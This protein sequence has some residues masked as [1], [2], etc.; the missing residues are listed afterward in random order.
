MNGVGEERRLSAE[1]RYALVLL[2]KSIMDQIDEVAYLKSNGYS[3]KTSQLLLEEMCKVVQEMEPSLQSAYY[4]L[5]PK[6][7]G[8]RVTRKKFS[9]EYAEGSLKSKQKLLQS[10]RVDLLKSA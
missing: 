9:T 6:L 3:A 1:Q 2:I 4:E 10:L 7:T 8:Q 5:L